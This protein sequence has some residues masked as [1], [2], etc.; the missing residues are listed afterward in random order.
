[1]LNKIYDQLLEKVSPVEADIQ[2]KQQPD[3]LSAFFKELDLY[4]PI[5]IRA[6]TSL[7]GQQACLQAVE[8]LNAMDALGSYVTNLNKSTF[9]K[10]VSWAKRRINGLKIVI[11]LSFRPPSRNPGC[12]WMPDQVRH[13]EIVKTITRQLINTEKRPSAT[14]RLTRSSYR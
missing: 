11:T 9:D 10:F 6:L 13:D 14:I 8:R 4:R 7:I 2:P 3:V 12:F 5:L 1:M